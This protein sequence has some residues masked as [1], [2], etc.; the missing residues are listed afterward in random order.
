MPNL[1][2]EHDTRVRVPLPNLYS[3]SES[4]QEWLRVRQLRSPVPSSMTSV[5]PH[6]ISMLGPPFETLE[7]SMHCDTNNFD[8]I[9]PPVPRHLSLRMFPCMHLPII[10]VAVRCVLTAH[11]GCTRCRIAAQFWESGAHFKFLGAGLEDVK[12][13]ASGW[14]SAASSILG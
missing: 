3:F 5:P 10:S 4:A 14:N 7:F 1:L 12:R 2:Q 8:S 9:P 11:H 6:P 13:V